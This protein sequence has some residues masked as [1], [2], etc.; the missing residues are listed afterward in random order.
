MRWSV[1]STSVV[2]I[3]AAGTLLAPHDENLATRFQDILFSPSAS[4]GL[5]LTMGR[6]RQSLMFGRYALRWCR[7]RRCRTCDRGPARTVDRLFPWLG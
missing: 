5:V 1:A 6:H 2:V 3:V 4:T 7:S